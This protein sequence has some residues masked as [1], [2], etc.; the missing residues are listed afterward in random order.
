LPTTAPCTT[1]T[2][3]MTGQDQRRKALWWFA[4]AYLLFAAALWTAQIQRNAGFGGAVL[5]ITIV[6]GLALTRPGWN[7]RAVGS[8]VQRCS[9]SGVLLVA[10]VAAALALT[11]IRAPLPYDLSKMRLL[12]VV[13]G[14]AGLILAEELLFRQIMFR[15][16]QAQ[17]VSPRAVI[18]L[19]AV[20]FG[21]AHLGSA[22]GPSSPLRLFTGLQAA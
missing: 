10:G 15:W 3:D 20:A 6:V 12:A 4:A 7:L 22:F 14:M 16:L 18:L 21:L 2:G 5:G 19:T 9:W 13:P 1:R 11:A 8:I 17:S